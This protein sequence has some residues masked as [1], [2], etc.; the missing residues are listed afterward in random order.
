VVEEPV[1]EA[2]VEVPDTAEVAEAPETPET[3]DVLE[4]AEAPE[5]VEEPVAEATVEVPDTAEVA[6]APASE[7]AAAGGYVA[8][9]QDADAAIGGL[10]DSASGS[11]ADSVTS[12]IARLAEL[13]DSGAI[14][15]EEFES[16]KQD[17]L[18]RL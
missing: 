4:V 18:D 16:R 6:E 15:A 7:V 5:T 12:A 17:L 2:T 14:T 8:A 3:A 9:L 13:R 10:T 1:A 11:G